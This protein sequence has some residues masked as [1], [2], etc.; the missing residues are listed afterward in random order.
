M[1]MCARGEGDC[2]LTLANGTLNR[3]YLDGRVESRKIEDALALI[4]VLKQDFLL[5]LREEEIEPLRA[6]LAGLLPG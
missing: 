2:R 6:R 1:L 3:R 4:E 5:D